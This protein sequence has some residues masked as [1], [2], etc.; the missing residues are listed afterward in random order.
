[1]AIVLFAAIFAVARPAAAGGLI[2]EDTKGGENDVAVVAHSFPDR[3]S[4]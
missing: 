1:M 3:C 4:V 2:Q